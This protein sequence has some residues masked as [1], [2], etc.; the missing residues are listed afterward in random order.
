ME[1]A[2]LTQETAEDRADVTNLTMMNITLTKQ[3][4]LYANHLSTKDAD[5]VAL[6]TAMKNL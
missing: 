4:A 3:V 1:F 6:L 2:H 5:N